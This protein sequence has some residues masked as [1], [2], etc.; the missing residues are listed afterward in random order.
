MANDG[1]KI[2]LAKAARLVGKSADTLR[3]WKR[4]GLISFEQEQGDDGRVRTMVTRGEVLQAASVHARDTSP[5]KS[6]AKARE[7]QESGELA[8]VRKHLAMVENVLSDVQAD[9]DHWR[10]QAT[11]TQKQ[12]EDTQTRLTAVERELNGGV[13]GLLRGVLRR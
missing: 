8:A 2:T 12:L 13:R 4:A 5:T 7:K 10:D 11:R 9:R 6:T 1:E 3:R